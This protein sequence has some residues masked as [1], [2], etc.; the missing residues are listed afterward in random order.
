M[1][2]VDIKYNNRKKIYFYIRKHKSTTKQNI[3]YDLKLSLPTVTQ[4]LEYLIEKKLISGD[5]KAKN[6]GYGRTPVAYSYVSDVKVAVGLDITAHHLKTVIIDLEGNIVKYTDKRLVYQR[7]DKYLHA[8]GD[9]V[10]SI[11]AESGINPK[12]V[13]GVGIAV[14]GL[15]DQTKGKVVYGKIVDN[16]G[17]TKEDFSKYIKY[18]TKL[19]HDSNAAGFFEIWMFPEYKN[20]Y[21]VNLSNTIGGSVFINGEVYLGDGLYSGEIGHL[22]LVPGGK[23][24]YCGNRGRADAYCGT[25]QLSA[26]TDGDLEVFF[27][28]LKQGD[29]NLIKIWDEYLEYLAVLINDIR[30]MFG[31]TII[32]GGSINRYIK[33]YMNIL[34]KKVD[35]KNPFSEEASQ[36]LMPGKCDIE[37]VASGAALYF[38]KDFLDDV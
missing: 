30:M 15:I 24:C 26:K 5:G 17:M 7:N 16:E 3:A 9:A 1:D 32:L 14:S 18:P 12:K 8:L 23:P 35:A 36:Y 21:Y 13:L 34:Y 19:I 38:V 37:V 2:I 25:E 28:S 20:A 22:N 29:K 10:D 6:R 33:D 27:N 4:N 31:C 11:I